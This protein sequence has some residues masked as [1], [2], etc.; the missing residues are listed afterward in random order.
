MRIGSLLALLFPLV[1]I[2]GCLSPIALSTME[3]TGN[4]TPVVLNHRGR[5]QGEG[6]FIAK[7]DD[8]TAATL[9][10]AV[11]LSLE[12]KEKKVEKNQAFFRFYDATEDRIDVFIVLRSDTMTSIKYDVG[13]FGSIAFGRLMFRQIISE[14]H[15]SKSFLQDWKN[16][17]NNR[18]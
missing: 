18:D 1:C 6:F 5:G 3:S 7:Y 12:V 8:V 2:E 11:A 14:L 9:R 17:I 16:Q 4:E 10:A 15:Q 13:W